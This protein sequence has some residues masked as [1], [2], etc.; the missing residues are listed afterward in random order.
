MTDTAQP[1][2][3]RRIRQTLET[4]LLNP[5]RAFRLRYLPLLMVYFAYGALGIITIAETFWIKS[6]L[7][8]TP[9]ELAA[10]SV[11]LTLPWTIKMV[12]GELVDAVPIMG[13]QRKVYVLIGGALVAVGLLVLAGAAGQWLTFA[14]PQNLYR[15]GSFLSVVGVVLQDVAADAMS[16]EVVDRHHPDGTPRDPKEVNRDLGMVQVLGRLALSFGMVAVAGVAGLLASV[17]SYETVFLLGLL[18]PLISVSGALLIHIPP[19]ETRP[20]DWRILGGGLAFGATVALL[21]VTG[22][23]FGQEI[24]FVFSMVVVSAMLWRIVRDL[25][26]RTQETIFYAAVIIFIFRATPLVGQGYTWFTIDVLG[27]DEAFQGT[28]NQIGAVLALLGTWLFSDAITRRPVPVVLFWLTIIG[29]ALSLPSLAL[30]LG[31]SDW[32]EAN[33][34]FGARTIAIIDTAASSP[35][36][37]L[38]MI[39]LLTLCAI[40]AP[41][42]RRATWFALMSS[43][44]NLALVA[45]ALQTKYV[46]MAL[47]VDRG[48]YDNLPELLALVMAIGLVA[49]LTAILLLGRKLNGTQQ[50]SASQAS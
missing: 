25:D 28:L 32:T 35:F 20:V 33:L 44:M 15:L 3:S 46:N 50:T 34:G 36:M 21:A 14:E 48:H 4:A 5:V 37:Q 13:S 24:V 43:L 1:A 17:Y 47:V 29:T 31:I 26:P 19:T 38:S 12:F 23:P 39:P 8:M 2:E 9:A 42:K 40:Y 11:W 7:T 10:L 16:T 27:F 41:P 49:P 45:S 18:I 22:M 6:A 30:T